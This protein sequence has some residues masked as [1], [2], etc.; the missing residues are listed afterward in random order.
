MVVRK[1]LRQKQ[2]M[3]SEELTKAK[4]NWRNGSSVT[5]LAQ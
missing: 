2:K 4:E 1:Q 3:L 5:V